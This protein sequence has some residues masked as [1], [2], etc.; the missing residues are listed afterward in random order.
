MK[1]LYHGNFINSESQIQGILFKVR[2]KYTKLENVLILI[3]YTKQFWIDV[4][5][6]FS[7]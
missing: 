3:A 2:N 7:I 1:P 4:N 5:L 6:L